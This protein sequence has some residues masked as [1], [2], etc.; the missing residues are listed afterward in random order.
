MGPLA[1][2][3]GERGAEVVVALRGDVH[4]AHDQEAV[5]P[6]DRGVHPRVEASD[7]WTNLPVV[8][9][10]DDHQAHVD[11][12]PDPFHDPDDLPVRRSGSPPAHGEEVEH[13][14]LAASAVE[15]RL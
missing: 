13:P 10:G 12:A 9:P 8:E 4:V 7:P 14:G 1:G 15:R 11:P 6:S 2:G 3:H 5:V